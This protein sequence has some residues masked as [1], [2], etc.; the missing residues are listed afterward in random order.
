MH[1]T[2]SFLLAIAAAGLYSCC[3][4]LGACRGMAELLEGA[5][6]FYRE[7]AGGGVPRTVSDDSSNSWVSVN[8]DQMEEPRVDSQPIDGEPWTLVDFNL[9]PRVTTVEEP[10][11]PPPTVLPEEQDLHPQPAS[12]GAWTWQR[13]AV[14]S[15]LVVGVGEIFGALS[16]DNEFD[17]RQWRAP[18]Q[19]TGPK[20]WRLPQSFNKLLK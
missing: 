5:E 16:N 10:L 1:L 9:D 14:A 11:P 13:M 17:P 3:C 6:E 7:A 4:L 18:S 19:W 20:G 12:S 15:A 8:R 2:A